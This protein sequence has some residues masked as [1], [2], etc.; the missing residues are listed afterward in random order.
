ML[1]GRTGVVFALL[2]AGVVAIG[3]AAWWRFSGAPAQPGVNGPCLGLTESWRLYDCMNRS[4][5]NREGVIS[6]GLHQGKIHLGVKA[7]ARQT[8]EQELTR[9]GIPSDVIVIEELQPGKTGGEFEPK[10]GTPLEFRLLATA[11]TLPAPEPGQGPDIVMKLAENAEQLRR[12][13][14]FFRL[15]AVSE[16]AGVDWDSEVVLFVGIGESG[17][18]PEKLSGFS[19][20]AEGILQA[21]TEYDGEFYVCTD[22]YSPRTFVAAVPKN[23]LPDGAI[24][25][26]VKGTYGEPVVQVR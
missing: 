1:R 14:L 18:C 7:R 24:R 11:K 5:W 16:P 13:W 23:S 15:E 22:D 4:H 21:H 26:T 6:S 25:A 12:L 17:S 19:L 10:D 9:L 3:L 8:V 20:S 2:L